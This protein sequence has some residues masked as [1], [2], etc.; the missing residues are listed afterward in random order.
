MA[1]DS[2]DVIVIGGGPAG[3]M[4]A[5][6]AAVHGRRTALFEALPRV[7]AKLLATGG[8]RCNLTNTLPADKL[9]ASFGKRGR[10]MSPA[11]E[12]LDS[13]ALREFFS[14]LGVP[15]HAEDSFHVF[16]KS[17]KALDVQEALLRRCRVSGVRIFTNCQVES[18]LFAEAS[19]PE[20]AATGDEGH[21]QTRI[22]TGVA[23]QG[24]V[25]QAKAAILATGGIGYPELG[26]KGSG[27][28]LAR[29]AGHSIVQPVPALAPLV[30][31]EE[32]P[33]RC[34]GIV[35]PRARLWID[36]PKCDKSGMAGEL[37]FT[38]RGI[39]GPAALDISGEVAAMLVD[40]GEVPLRLAPHADRDA[41][42]WRK[43]VDAWPASAGSRLVRNLVD[44]VLPSTLAVE[45]CKLAGS[46]GE[47][48][49]AELSRR[50]R[51]VLCQ[52]L[53]GLPLTCQSTEGFSRAMVTRGGV[54]LRGVD[55]RTLESRLVSGL[56]F[57]GE[58]LDLDG[59]CG[60][61][62]LQWA[63]SSGMLAGESAAV[64]C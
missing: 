3:L 36:Q 11:L 4:A 39:S 22:L 43:M 62:N 8:G 30:I 13:C 48:R 26:G 38:H 49:A 23:A 7:G 24:Q 32:W 64:A 57:A 55:P 20:D 31:K 58:A 41:N 17:E 28:D 42:A 34:A 37:L 6:S 14:D 15:S 9:M 12:L 33:R 61:Y 18:F 53:A 27:Y 19:L 2:F 29:Q 46:I 16:P 25:W 44:Q 60:G 40:R 59:P 54:D 52:L 10:F 63:F 51:E 47:I 1:E 45:A 56:F 5:G 50:N 21:L 35:L